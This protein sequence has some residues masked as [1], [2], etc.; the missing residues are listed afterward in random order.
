MTEHEKKPLPPGA[1]EDIRGPFTPDDPAYP[2]WA[3]GQ[4]EAI[5]WILREAAEP[6][7]E[8]EVKA[9]CRERGMVFTNGSIS[10]QIRNLRKPANGG[11]CVR[12]HKA[13]DDHPTL[14]SYA[15]D[16]HV[17]EDDQNAPAHKCLVCGF[18]PYAQLHLY[19]ALRLYR[20]GSERGDWAA[21]ERFLR[22]VLRSRGMLRDDEPEPERPS[23]L[24][25]LR[26]DVDV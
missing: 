22:D 3:R 15:A 9:R 26:G 11:F 10:A 6:L 14:Y 20:E 7:S 12:T 21:T 4:L 1:G 19:E 23:W 24:D 25:L 2:E 13:D 8:N 18:G 5:L 16:E 17:L